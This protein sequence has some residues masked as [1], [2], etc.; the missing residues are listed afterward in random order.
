V[1]LTSA[2]GKPFDFV[3]RNDPRTYADLT[4]AAG[5]A[6]SHGYA[7]GIGP[8]KRQIVPLVNGH[9]GTPTKL[10]DLGH[11][12]DLLD[13][14]YTMRNEGVF[15]APEYNG[16]PRKELDQLFA[17]GVDGLFSDFPNTAH[18]EAALLYPTTPA[19]F[20]NGVGLKT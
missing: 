10:V 8:D 5:L 4:T 13:H 15:L 17:L 16:D 12:A 19:D 11:A 18:D 9:L 14:P 6:F 3:V 7:D 2:S 1:Q 20:L